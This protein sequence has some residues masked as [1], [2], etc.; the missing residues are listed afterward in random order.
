MQA[1]GIGDFLGNGVSDI[2][3]QNNNGQVSI[4][5]MNGNSIEQSMI[6]PQNPGTSWH[7]IGTGDYIGNGIS[8]ILFRNTNGQI[9]IWDM[10][11]FS[12]VEG[13]HDRSRKVLIERSA[14]HTMS[15]GRS[16]RLRHLDAH[17]DR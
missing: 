1:I 16:F 9:A 15:S 7:A 13:A 5:E 11:G 2:V 8:D 10:N 14:T 12:I 17:R 3:F 6:I 4:W